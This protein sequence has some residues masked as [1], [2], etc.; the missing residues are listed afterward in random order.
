MTRRPRDISGK[1]LVKRLARA[2]FQHTKTVG[3]HATCTS[4]D[5][6]GFKVYIPLHDSIAVGTLHSILRR[7]SK[8]LEIPLDQ[9]TQLLEL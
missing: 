4:T 9:L 7:V 1:E 2:G 3:S 5:R 6:G 8:H